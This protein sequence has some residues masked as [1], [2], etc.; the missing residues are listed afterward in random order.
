MIVV[1]YN[2]SRYIA[3][4]L[5]SVL[6][7]SYEAIELII[8]DDASTDDT[9][10]IA[11]S[12]LDR[13]GDRFV[14][15]S[16]V[17]GIENVGI[18]ANCNRA[19][20]HSRGSWLKLIAA[21]DVLLP[22]CIGDYVENA[23]RHPGVSVFF[24]RMEVIDENGMAGGEYLYPKAF[25]G[26]PA[27]RQLKY[28]LHR[29]CL[30]APSAFLRVDD[31][32]AAGGFD[33]AFPMLEDLPLWI[34]MLRQHRRFGGLDKCTVRYRRH[35]SLAWPILG[36]RDERYRR[37]L[38]D[39]DREVRIPLSRRLSPLLH[40][41]V[42]MDIVVDG[43]VQRPVAAWALYPFLWLWAKLGPFTIKKQSHG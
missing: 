25:F 34:G 26:F 41:T 16:L 1:A 21:D 2:S 43:I 33:E 31:L 8:A 32:R 3:E 28:L 30:P 22:G 39:F 12:W 6:A 14:A 42:R 4:T 11:R 36:K 35:P 29:N 19:L 24:S 9:A 40:L 18:A 7:Q 10:S 15:A 23:A 13:Y 17:G 20:G 38:R 37:T 5:D 27:E